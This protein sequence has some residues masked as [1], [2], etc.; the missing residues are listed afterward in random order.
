MDS[1]LE[2]LKDINDGVSGALDGALC[3]ETAAAAAREAE[4]LFERPVENARVLWSTFH[5]VC[6]PGPCGP[7]REDTYVVP[8]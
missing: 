8:V 6:F 5:A 3:R 2:R 4:E 1:A 7:V